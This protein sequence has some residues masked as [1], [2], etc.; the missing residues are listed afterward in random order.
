MVWYLPRMENL[1]FESICSYFS[2]CVYIQEGWIVTLGEEKAT[3]KGAK[4]T[5]GPRYVTA[6][7]RKT[8]CG[9]RQK[10]L[11]VQAQSPP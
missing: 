4:S 1:L 5:L 3:E 2:I 11:G 9:V 10:R 6:I 8:V 7:S